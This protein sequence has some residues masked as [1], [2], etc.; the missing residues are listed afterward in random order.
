MNYYKIYLD[1][2]EKAKTQALD[3]NVYVEK[4]HIVP[5][6]L[7]GLNCEENIVKFTGRQ[8]YVA[9]E[10]LVMHYKHKANLGKD[11][12][13]YYKMLKALSAMIQ[14]PASKDENGLRKRLFKFNSK[15]YDS[16]K[17][18]LRIAISKQSSERI[19]RLKQNPEK[20]KDYCQKLSNSLKKRYQEFGG[21]WVGRH[22]S[23]ESKQ[24]MR[25]QHQKNHLQAG[26]KNSQFGMIAIYNVETFE[27]AT[28]PKDQPIPKGWE[29]GRFYNATPEEL[30]QRKILVEKI[31]EL[32][33]K[34]K[35]NIRWK[36]DK[37]QKVFD[38]L[39]NPKVK[40]SSTEKDI[41]I[42]RLEREQ[43]LLEKIQLLNEMYKFYSV[44]GFKAMVEK[45]D[46][47]YTKTNFVQ[48][49]ARYVKDFVPQNGKKR[50]N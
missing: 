49:C 11:K 6:S 40:V 41:D 2:V 22:H 43:K 9:H 45:Y 47:K 39:L 7:G 20:Y 26:E 5:K 13:P 8:H 14:L 44:F 23:E 19:Q 17:K 18:E 27:R 21:T 34:L 50:G 15:L 29:Q 25:E 12:T 32:D 10:L 48:Q 42:R 36:L 38:K 46:Y 37:L 1:L 24:K 28:Q 35:A 31:L 16:W 3:D 4:H 33:N 30:K